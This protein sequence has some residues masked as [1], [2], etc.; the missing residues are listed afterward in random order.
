MLSVEYMYDIF[1]EF[2]KLWGT[3]RKERNDGQ[4]NTGQSMK[5]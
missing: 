1:G 4:L 3:W 2:M 5:I